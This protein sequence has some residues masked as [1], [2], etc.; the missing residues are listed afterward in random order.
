MQT[1]VTVFFQMQK[2]IGF[3]PTL[4]QIVTSG[5]VEGPVR[6]AGIIYLKNLI[7]SHWDESADQQSRKDQQPKVSVITDQDR[8]VIRETI[9][10]A[11]INSPEVIR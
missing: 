10:E 7:T 2:I 3:A 9:V 11:V 5:Q 1:E 8:H 6:Q 4:L